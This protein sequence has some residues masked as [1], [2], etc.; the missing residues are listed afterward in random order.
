MGTPHEDLTFVKSSIATELGEKALWK[1]LDWG[2]HTP[3]EV[4]GQSRIVAVSQHTSDVL[5]ACYFRS[6]VDT[7]SSSLTG[8]IDTLAVIESRRR[9]GI[10]GR[11][12]SSTIDL[13]RAEGAQEIF[14]HVRRHD[15]SPELH[16]FYHCHGFTGGDPVRGGKYVLFSEEQSR[17]I[18]LAIDPGL[19]APE[20]F[21]VQVTPRSGRMPPMGN[22]M[23]QWA[24][25]DGNG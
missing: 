15:A 8:T 20:G 13:I 11:I 9:S 5:A 14:L 25:R 24:P 18:T 17:V 7:P 2:L 16:R 22:D 23:G 1:S 4:P 12:L 21:A 6:I 10:G 19:V 3:G